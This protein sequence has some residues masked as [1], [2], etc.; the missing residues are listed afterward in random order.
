MEAVRGGPQS[1]SYHAHAHVSPSKNSTNC[2]TILCYKIRIN[3]IL[4][5]L[6]RYSPPPTACWK[7]LQ[8]SNHELED[9]VAS[10]VVAGQPVLLSYVY[11]EH[12]CSS[13]F[14]R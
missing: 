2:K 3:I 12:R 9:G 6:F 8:L 11:R 13:C 10:F 7:C 14:N 5:V 1:A 4:F